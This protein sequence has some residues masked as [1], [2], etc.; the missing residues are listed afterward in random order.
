MSATGR[1]FGS[2]NITPASPEVI[3]AI[4][5]ANTGALH[6]YGDDPY[7]R[8]L[9]ALACDLFET[10]VT[11]Y[12]VTTGTAANAL[13]LATLTPPYGAV[14]CHET[15][16]IATD[17]CGAPEFYTAGAKIV[18]LPGMDGKLLPAQL[19]AP[20]RHAADLGVH[21]VQPA[22]LSLTQATEWGTVYVPAEVQALSAAAHA[23]RLGVH[24]DGARIA[25]AIV[26]L[27]CSPADITWK[28]GVDVLSLGATKN[29]AMAAEAVIFFDRARADGFAARRK[30][31]GH[32]WSK[33]RFLSVQLVAYLQDE[34]WL[35]NARHA[36]TMAT[37][38]AA[39]LAVLPG[40]RLLL[41]VQANE[42]FVSIPERVI[43]ALLAEGFEFYRWA[44]PAGVCGPVI[45]LVTSFCTTAADVD[46]FVAAAGSHAS[47]QGGSCSDGS[48]PG[49][50]Q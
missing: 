23:H 10:E 7:T 13:A 25:N 35:R 31:A 21:H 1:N 29:G 20:L 14:Y 48:G 45:R 40:L 2:D 24:M 11:I 32:L 12:P 37:R 36:N 34:L 44:A 30:R 46:A 41:P 9:D 4:S 3:D 43:A 19:D 26:H 42:L 47:D 5:A 17:E 27:G 15:A 8:R 49:G 16:H 33:M 18:G 38:L 28:S 50:C 6:A 39:G 22:A